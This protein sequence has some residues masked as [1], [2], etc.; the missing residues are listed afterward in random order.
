MISR[1]TITSKLMACCGVMLVLTLA[2]AYSSF[3]TFRSLGGQLKEAV[4]SE[5]AKISLAGA[6]GEAIC[7]LL[8]LE[9]GI[10]L[11]AGDHEQAAQLDREFQGKFG[12]AVE[13]LKG[14]QPLLETPV[15][16]QTA[17]LADEGLREWETVHRD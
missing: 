15:E 9:R 5:A 3:V 16:R 12:E 2:L 8:S 6:L 13:A 17:A 14:L 4:T 10:V 7:D 11:A 1:K